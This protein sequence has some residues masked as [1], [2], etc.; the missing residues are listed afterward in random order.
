MSQN[1]PLPV[2][3]LPSLPAASF[4]EIQSLTKALKGI[5]SEIQIDIVDGKFV[6]LVSWPFTEEDPVSSLSLLVQFTNDYRIE[7]D[8]MV[9][10]PEQYL[11]VFVELGVRRVIIHVGSTQAY[12]EIINHAKVY[13]YKIGFALTNDTPLDILLEHIDELD[14][15]Q[16][17]GIKEVGQQGQPF[18]ERTLKRA[19]ELRSQ[20]PELE[21][22]VDG[23]VNAQTMPLLYAAGVTRFAPG[24]AIAKT[25]DPAAAYKHLLSLVT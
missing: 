18:D 5:S 3:V 17:M 16:L 7:M 19:R 6:P 10:N 8:C 21:I 1:N 20:F 25:N 12:G 14:F 4:S 23:S 13:G 11:D 22:A 9:L 24:S 15:V 2:T